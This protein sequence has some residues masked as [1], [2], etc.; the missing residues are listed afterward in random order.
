MK[1]QDDLLQCQD[2]WVRYRTLQDLLGRPQEDPAVLDARA[3]MLQ[4][5]L[6]RSLLD[7]LATWPGT[8]I[9]SHKSA[10]QLYHKLAFL[11]DI[12]MNVHDDGL[13]GILA[14]IIAHLSPEGLPQLPMNIPQHFGGTG[15]DQWAWA[16]CDTPLQ[17]YILNKMGLSQEK[18]VQNGIDYLTGLVRDNGWPCVVSKELGSFRGPG[19]KADPCPYATLLMLKLLLSQEET[20]QIPAVR[21]GAASLLDLWQASQEQ[22]P[23]QFYMGTDFRKLK[24]PFIWYDLLHVAEILSQSDFARADQRFLAMLDL[25]N[26]KAGQNGL[27]TPES[28]WK[29][30][31]AWEFG[32]KKQ[33]SF[34]LTFLVRRINFR[35][36][37]GK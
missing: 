16:L 32:Q 5:P 12:G 9:S 6:V 27:F 29:A 33:P 36:A 22:H 34:W 7:E 23:Y 8:V 2:P 24:A 31:N 13:N 10:G 18:P 1:N 15:Q 37:G 19:R 3:G 26:S 35:V 20:R 17:L 4:H 14:R 30:W 21:Q 28:E 11:A 25:I